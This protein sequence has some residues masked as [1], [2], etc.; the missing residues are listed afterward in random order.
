VLQEK[1]NNDNDFRFENYCSFF[2]PVHRSFVH[3][4]NR[5]SEVQKNPSFLGGTIQ[6]SG[7]FLHG[8]SVQLDTFS[9]CFQGIGYKNG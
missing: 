3:G 9:G 1:F 2:L 4:K 8:F 6:F 7:R 5:N